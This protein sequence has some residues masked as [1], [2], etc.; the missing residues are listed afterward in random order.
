MNSEALRQACEVTKAT[1]FLGSNSTCTHTSL[2]DNKFNTW[3]HPPLPSSTSFYFTF[4]SFIRPSYLHHNSTPSS[5]QDHAGK[6]G[7]TRYFVP[8]HHIQA[9][10]Q[11]AVANTG[12]SSSPF[13]SHP[14]GAATGEPGETTRTTCGK[15][16]T[17]L[18]DAHAHSRPAFIVCLHRRQSEWHAQTNNQTAIVWSPR[19]I[20]ET[21]G[22]D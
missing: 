5:T 7:T 22:Q 13:P 11:Q 10:R 4:S 15:N 16:I 3:C 6:H 21:A 1:R 19:V 2:P 9:A 12:I 17:L 20:L 8:P 18:H 14:F